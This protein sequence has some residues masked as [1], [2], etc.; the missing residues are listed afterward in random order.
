MAF[1]F[2]AGYIAIALLIAFCSGFIIDDNDEN[3]VV[4]L[5]AGAWP[6]TVLGCC[7]AFLVLAALWVFNRTI[8]AGKNVRYRRRSKCA[9]KRCKYVISSVSDD[10]L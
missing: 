1:L 6:I 7:V 8:I 2:I 4:M 9:K 5:I 10:S 3:A